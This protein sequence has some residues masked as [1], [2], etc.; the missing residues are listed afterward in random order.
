MGALEDSPKFRRVKMA[1]EE[2]TRGRRLAEQITGHKFPP[3]Q[4]EIDAYLAAGLEP[5]TA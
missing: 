4:G 1:P 2:I 3:G 5:P